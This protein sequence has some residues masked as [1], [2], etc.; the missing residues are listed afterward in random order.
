MS[1][2]SVKAAWREEP[3]WHWDWPGR[4]AQNLGY[5]GTAQTESKEPEGGT[6]AAGIYLPNAEGWELHQ[7]YKDPPLPPEQRRLG[8]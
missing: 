5:W 6:L 7:V 8:L 1:K 3:W 2:W 4:P